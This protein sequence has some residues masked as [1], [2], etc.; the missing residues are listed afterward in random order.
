MES[1]LSIFLIA[2]ALA[3]ALN[4]LLKRF[5]IPTIIGYIATGAVIAQVFDL[6][7]NADLTHVAEF[8]IVFLMFTIGLEFSIK[9]LI[10]MK[11]EVF[12]N[13]FLQV[14]ISGGIYSLGAQYVFG[15]EQKSAIIIGFA[16]ALSSTAIVL[17]V[18]NDSG[19][20]HTT[21][22][23]KSLGILLFQDIAVI[24]LLLMITI[25]AAETTSISTLLQETVVSA[26]I[27]LL[28]LFVVGK[29]LL[30]HL[31]LHVVATDSEETFVATILFLVIGASYLAHAFGFTY[32]LGAFVAGMMIAETKFKYQIEADLIP[33]RDLL[34]G[35]FFIT[36]GLQVDVAVLAAYWEVIF[37]VIVA[38]MVI[39]AVIIFG[40]L[41][42]VQNR[43]IALQTAI[44]ISQ[45]GEFSLAVFELARANAIIPPQM[46]Q[47]L[48][49]MVVVSMLLTPLILRHVRWIADILA[50]ATFADEY[51]VVSSEVKNHIVVCGYGKLGQE[52]VYRLKKRS[53]P[54]L[55]IEHDI[56]LVQLGRA[57]NEPVFFG[58]ASHKSILEAASV[59]TSAAVIVAVHNEHK[60][61]L[62]CEAIKGFKASVNLVVRVADF[63]EKKLIESL[64]VGHIVNEGRETAKALIHEALQCRMEKS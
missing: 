63:E 41:R 12:V 34:L 20:I 6:H 28:L 59:G 27:V 43:R 32:S 56:S 23:R 35:L 40:I 3:V 51:R 29:Y 58:N 37:G 5:N 33:F 62:I 17:K 46:A 26:T 7:G 64:E 24:P 31:L 36:V 2:V 57:R 21:Y 50:P 19:D 55:V 30:N 61:R 15:I 60:L 44:S 38:V 4:V 11:K 52:I 16:L 22:G 9:H 42:V 39:K 8:G 25:F 49:M 18:L 10:A 48:I 14:A 54:Y 13:G 53:I 47:V 45:V 1:F